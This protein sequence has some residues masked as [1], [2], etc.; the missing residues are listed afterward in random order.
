[1]AVQRVLPGKFGTEI[2]EMS[3]LKRNVV[4]ITVGPRTKEERQACKNTNGRRKTT[5]S[6]TETPQPST[7]YLDHILNEQEKSNYLS[8]VKPKRHGI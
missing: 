5:L 7:I 8:S 1:M 3:L 2:K 4:V 6:A